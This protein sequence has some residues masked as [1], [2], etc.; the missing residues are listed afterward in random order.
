MYQSRLSKLEQLRKL[1]P[2]TKLDRLTKLEPLLHRRCRA[3]SMRMCLGPASLE[4]L[5]QSAALLLLKSLRVHQARH[6]LLMNGTN[7]Q[8]NWQHQREQTRRCLN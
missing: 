8:Q 2:I 7:W 6:P 5:H 3:C 4:G 1:D